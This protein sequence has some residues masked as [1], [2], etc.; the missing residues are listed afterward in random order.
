VIACLSCPSERAPDTR[1]GL[2]DRTVILTMLLA[3]PHHSEVFALRTGSPETDDDRTCYRVR[4]K[5]SQ[6]CRRDL[7]RP[8]LNAI[9]ALW[10]GEGMRLA[11]LSLEMPLFPI[12]PGGFYQNLRAYVRRAATRR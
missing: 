4:V 8:V 1:T 12:T 7:P 11:A 3:G 9:A 5:G 2:P 10:A 6:E